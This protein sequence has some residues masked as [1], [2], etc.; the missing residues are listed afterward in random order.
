MVHCFLAY[1][2][3]RVD[4]TA[5]NRNGKNKP[6]EHFLHVEA[7]APAISAKAEYLLYRNALKSNILKR[8]EL[9]GIEMKT[10]L[11]ARMEGLELLK[12]NLEKNG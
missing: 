7:V 1:E 2:A 11:N 9:H 5:D 6:I 12:S 8:S 10:F 4:L 3:Y